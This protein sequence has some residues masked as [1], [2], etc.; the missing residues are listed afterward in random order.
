MANLS[1]F[2]KGYGSLQVFLFVSLFLPVP[3]QLLFSQ[4]CEK[5]VSLLEPACFAKNQKRA[6][7]DLTRR[8][9]P[10]VIF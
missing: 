9:Y 3:E 1:P 7:K 5:I 2:Q 8:F 6:Q 4:V 10:F